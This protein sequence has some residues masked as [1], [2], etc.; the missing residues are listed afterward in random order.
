M[1]RRRTPFCRLRPQVAATLLVSAS[2]TP[3]SVNLANDA[4]ASAATVP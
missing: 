4:T 2:A 3:S 1:H